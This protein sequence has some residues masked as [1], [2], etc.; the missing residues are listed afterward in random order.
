[1][2]SCPNHH[3]KP[4]ARARRDVAGRVPGLVNSLIRWHRIGLCSLP[5]PRPFRGEIALRPSEPPYPR[6]NPG[7][8]RGDVTAPHSA[9][10]RV[11]S[12][13]NTSALTGT[14]CDQIG[15]YGIVCSRASW[16]SSR[17]GCCRRRGPE[18]QTPPAPN[19]GLLPRHLWQGGQLIRF[20]HGDDADVLTIIPALG[21][22]GAVRVAY[23]V[24]L[25]ELVRG[26]G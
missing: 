16:G 22:F 25:V 2:G 5:R 21:R 6:A 15:C 20:E 1:M 24:H 18:A 3:A 7:I 4:G 23:A 17:E 9:E 14:C 12:P 19:N 10:L 13:V 26:G 11:P 8:A